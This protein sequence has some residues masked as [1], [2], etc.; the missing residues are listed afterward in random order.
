MQK[1][2]QKIIQTLNTKIWWINNNNNNN[3]SINDLPLICK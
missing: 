3:N 1:K 2:T